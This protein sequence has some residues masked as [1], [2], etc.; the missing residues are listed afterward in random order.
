MSSPNVMRR[1]TMILGH[2]KIGQAQKA[3]ESFW[4]MQHLRMF[5]QTLY[6]HGGAECMC[7]RCTWTG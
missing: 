1:T 2:L 5:N 6:F 4:Q 3:L 7:L